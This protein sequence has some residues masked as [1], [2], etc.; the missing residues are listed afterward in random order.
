MKV[1][2][3]ATVG[4]PP[5]TVWAALHDRALLVRAVPGCERL[6]IIGPDSGRFIVTTAMTAIGG[7]Y[8]GQLTASA[9]QEPSSVDLIASV[10]SSQGTVTADLA[11]RL[12]P[13]PGGATL[14]GYEATGVVSGAIAGVGARLLASA[15]KRL[16]D[17][18]L[19][20]LDEAVAELA[21]GDDP[22]EPPEG[23]GASR[24]RLPS[25][26]VADAPHSSVQAAPRPSEPGPGSELPAGFGSE[27]PEPPAKSGSGLVSR[28]DLKTGVLVGAALAVAGIAAVLFRRLGR[29]ARSRRS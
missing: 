15:A 23:R 3:E 19:A 18:F 13:V 21:R 28:L 16:A 4:A 11:I 14:V 17:E 24:H 27:L 1:T 8:S 9:Q 29:R 20:A 22:P 5:E 7:T 12:S 6:D 25:S 10:S 2:G 26:L